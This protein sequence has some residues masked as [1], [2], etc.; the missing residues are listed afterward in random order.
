M[1]LWDRAY[2]QSYNP[3]FKQLKS[4]QVFETFQRGEHTAGLWK[5]NQ[6]AII[7]FIHLLEASVFKWRRRERMLRF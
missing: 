1:S 3:D 6:E 4:F 2:L 5:H 7:I